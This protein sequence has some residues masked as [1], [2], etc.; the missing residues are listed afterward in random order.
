MRAFSAPDQVHMQVANHRYPY[1]EPLPSAAGETFSL[2]NQLWSSRDP[3]FLGII[4]GCLS[5][6]GEAYQS[7]TNAN[8]PFAT[9]SSLLV[10]VVPSVDSA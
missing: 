6:A 9:N 1:D 2:A 3:R 7:T 4:F 5:Q 10:T 8:R